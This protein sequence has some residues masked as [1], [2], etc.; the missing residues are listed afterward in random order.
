ME[1]R[2]VRCL[3]GAILALGAT[4]SALAQDVIRARTVAVVGEE[5]TPS[6]FLG[7]VSGFTFDGAGRLYVTDFKEPRIVVLDSTGRPLGVIGRSGE[8]PGEFRAPTGP[9]FA[10]DGS[11]Y[12]RNMSGVMRF[13]SDPQTGLTGRFDRS[14]AGPARADWRSKRAGLIDAEGRLYF[15]HYA[16][17]MD[18]PTRYSFLRYALDGTRVDSI[19]VPSY[20]TAVS[21]SAAYVVSVSRGGSSGRMVPGLNAAPFAPIPVFAATPRGTIVSGAGDRY[22]LQETGL[23]AAGPALRTFTRGIADLRVPAA[24]RAESLAAMNRRIDS[25]PVPLE[26]LLGASEDVRNRRVPA[27]YPAVTDVAVSDGGDVWV[28]RWPARPGVTTFD[29]FAAAGRY[30][31]TVEID[32]PC[33]MRPDPVIRG[34]RFACLVVDDDTGAEQ[35]LIATLPVRR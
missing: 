33:A 20:P 30:L 15:P 23:D 9:V 4:T 10:R 32:R 14:F 35:V 2:I 6:V 7:E 5:S 22:A 16:A 11:L 19:P 21:G 29:V 8:G 18:G 26:K 13:V 1:D 25:L 28:R 31:H 27:T 24:V 34:H 12:V 17:R 3:G